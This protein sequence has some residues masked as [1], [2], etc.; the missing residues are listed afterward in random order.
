M[1]IEANNLKEL[2]KNLGFFDGACRVFIDNIDKKV[3]MCEEHDASSLPYGCDWQ[4]L[5]SDELDC[6]SWKDL[7]FSDSMVFIYINFNDI[8][9]IHKEIFYRNV[10]DS[11]QEAIKFI[12]ELET[13][14]C[15]VDSVGYLN[16]IKEKALNALNN[17]KTLFIENESLVLQI[18]V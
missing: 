11:K 3:F 12:N 4:Y 2:F 6:F 13:I 5:F 16:D 15:E 10:F 1:T 14:S 18:I 9:G 8:E 7:P 17:S